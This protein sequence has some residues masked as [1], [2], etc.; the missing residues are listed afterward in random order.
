MGSTYTP[1]FGAIDEENE[2]IMDE[3]T[4][5]YGKSLLMTT[6]GERTKT[7]N[8]EQLKNASDVERKRIMRDLFAEFDILL[9]QR[10]FEKSVELLLKITEHA[11][12]LDTAQQLVYKQKQTELIQT[13]RRDLAQA[14]ERGNS[15]GVVKTGKRVV[16]SLVRLNIYDEAIDL[17]ID[18]HKYLN[19]ETVKRIKLEESNYVYMSNLLGSF[20]ENLTESF[21]AFR[22]QFALLLNYCYS[23][24]ISWCDT[25]IEILIKK[26]QSQHY[27]GRH[28]DVTVENSELF[29]AKAREFTDTCHFDVHFLVQTKL[30]PVLENS[31]REQLEI[32]IDASI[33]RSKLELNSVISKV[34]RST[35]IK[36]NN[37]I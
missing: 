27:L 23:T 34:C 26:M 21:H 22:E 8:V 32:L 29:M 6:S 35:K 16:N 37:N 17:F 15:K 12:L 28:F 4:I 31:I 10:D 3:N 13:L 30:V 1:E 7:V 18:Y 36:N 11:N 9:A 5:N 2:A 19:A 24:Y 25:E 20:F 14:K 33:Q